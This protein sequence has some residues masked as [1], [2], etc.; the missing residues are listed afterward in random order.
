MNAFRNHPPSARSLL[1]F[2][3][4]VLGFQ[5]AQAQTNV[6]GQWTFNTDTAF[7]S[8]GNGNHGVL[9]GNFTFVD[10]PGFRGI[11]LDGDNAAQSGVLIPAHADFDMSGSDGVTVE[12]W[13]DIDTVVA[14]QG[15][16]EWIA[17]RFDSQ[18]GI[19]YKSDG[20]ANRATAHQNG[21]GAGETAPNL[22]DGAG[23]YHLVYTKSPAAGIDFYINGVDQG[24]TGGF[25]GWSDPVGANDIQI[26]FGGG[27][28]LVGVW[29]EVTIHDV[30]LT[31]NEVFAS[32]SA[33]P[34]TNEAETVVPSS[35]VVLN[36]VLTTEFNSLPNKRYELESATDVVASNWTGAGDGF[37]IGNG[38][39]MFMS[40]PTG[41]DT[42]KL[43]RLVVQ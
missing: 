40:A 31:S 39:N 12:A 2:A 18:Y 23:F 38:T 22:I 1:G 16:N 36:D 25:A 19:G 42:G 34:S 28:A 29:D 15:N 37:V 4:L 14:G 32:F 41:V 9:Q 20:G 33:G 8:S 7:D 43:Y 26:G 35:P 27:N 11:S 13:V 10:T 5:A 3:L 30:V 17:R 21:S 6:I 24:F